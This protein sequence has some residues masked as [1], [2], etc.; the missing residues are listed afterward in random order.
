MSSSNSDSDRQKRREPVEVSS[1]SAKMLKKAFYDENNMMGRDSLF[2]ILKKQYPKTHPTEDEIETWLKRQEV[3]QIYGA[4][5]KGGSS[6]RFYP[7]KP[8]ANISIDLIDFSKKVGP[9][10]MKHMLVVIDNFSRFMMTR[11]MVNKTA[12]ITARHLESILD[13]IKRDFNKGKEIT[14]IITDDGSEFKGEV[15]T[16][17]K[18]RDIGIQRTLGGNPAS[19]GLVERSNGKLKIIISKI[20]E[21]RGGSWTTHLQEGT[22]VY[23]RQYNRGIG[24]SPE[25]A[26]KLP[27]TEQAAVKKNNKAAHRDK[28]GSGGIVFKT[29]QRFEV[30]DRVRRKLNKG[31]LDKASAPSWSAEIFKVTKVTAKRGSVAEKYRISAK[32]FGDKTFTRNDLQK[33]IGEV[34]KAPELKRAPTRSEK[35]KEAVEGKRVTRSGR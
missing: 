18:E 31:K 6:D 17:L 10:N 1:R 23:N 24:F 15:I 35:A 30:G 14:K 21:Y 33:V 28:D 11:P 19:N 25:D 8:W 27:R 5:R 29:N 16:L 9:G 34:E 4:T 12:A 20:R 7:T 2:Y 13:E 26:V 32:G 3:Q 22:K